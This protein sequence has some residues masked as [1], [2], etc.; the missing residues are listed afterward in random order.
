MP[1]R[2]SSTSLRA[3]WMLRQMPVPTSTTDTCISGLTRSF[4]WSRPL[5]MISAL[6]CDRRSRLIGSMVMNSSSM[7]MFRLGFMATLR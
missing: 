3:S 7:P 2:I 1:R 4:N 5:A 6:M